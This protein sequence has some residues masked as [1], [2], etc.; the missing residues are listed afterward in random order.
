[1]VVDR[2]PPVYDADELK[3]VIRDLAS[4]NDISKS[5]YSRRSSGKPFQ[6]DI[7]ELNTSLP[8]IWSDGQPAVH[9]T[10][11]YWLVIGNT[12]DLHRNHE[13]VE[14]TQ[15][16][17]IISIDSVLVNERYDQND[18]LTYAYSRRFYLPSWESEL[19]SSFSF[20][21][22]LRPVTVHKNAIIDHASI[23]ATM[24]QHSWLLLHSCLVRFLA[25]DDGRFD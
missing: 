22:F 6:G 7:I 12:C 15:I 2:W 8:M 14:F 3:Q 13:D 23:K 24:N 19:D 10:F 5:F 9:G 18:F 4:S 17:P 1:M 21:D 20:A 11:Q 25:R 16:V